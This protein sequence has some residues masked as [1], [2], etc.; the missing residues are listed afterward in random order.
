MP[1]ASF[2]TRAIS[3]PLLL[4]SKYDTGRR[5]S[6]SCTC[7]RISVI[8]RWAAT[9]STCERAN[10]ARPWTSVAAATVS[11]SHPQQLDA[12]LA[13]DVVDE[14]FRGRRQ[15]QARRA[16]HDHQPQAQGQAAATRPEQG[17]RLAPGLPEVELL[18]FGFRVVGHPCIVSQPRRRPSHSGQ[19]PGTLAAAL[20]TADQRR[21]AAEAHRRRKNGVQNT[22]AQCATLSAFAVPS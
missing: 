1:S 5:A 10:D 14:Q 19:T 15:H 20:R 17:P 22:L 3:A 9:P 8:E 16:A 12:L 7:L 11:A 2:I 6:F 21:N 18:L 13:D 4:A